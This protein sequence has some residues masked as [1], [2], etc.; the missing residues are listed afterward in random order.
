MSTAE[1]LVPARSSSKTALRL[2]LSLALGALGAGCSK[3]PTPEQHLAQ[4][5]QALERSKLRE[6][7]KEYSEV[8]RLAPGNTVA[9]R[10]LG[11]LYFAQGQLRQAFSFLKRAADSEPKDLDVQIMIARSYLAGRQFQPARDIAQQL[12][13]KQPGQ[14][15][16][17]ILLASAGVGLNDI[18][19]TRAFLE[20]VRPEDK[21]RAGYHVAQAILLLA[22]K[23]DGGAESELKAA[24]T[25]DPKWDAAHSGLATFYWAHNDLKHAEEEF[26]TA[27]AMAPKWSAQRLQLPEFLIETGAVDEAKRILEQTNRE[28][29]DYLPPR[30]LLMRIACAEK[31]DDDCAARAKAILEQ[32]PGNFDAL[33]Q[34]GTFKLAKGDV[35][36]AAREFEFV[37]RNYSPNPPAKY[38]LARAILLQ[39]QTATP[40]EGQK[41]IERAESNLLDAVRLDP[42]FAPAVLALA[43]LKIKKG[44][45]A[46]ALEYLRPLVE[47]N[48]TS[49]QAQ[50][51]LASAYVAE[52]N[53]TEALAVYRHMTELFPQDPKPSFL[54]GL[55][56][57]AQGQQADARKA[58]EKAIAI[59]PDLLPATEK[60][61]DLDL[62]N[63]QL[64]TALDRIQKQVDRDAHSAQALAIRAKV[65][66]AQNDLAHAEADLTRSIELNPKLE[67]SYL[68]L[69]RIYIV[70]NRQQQAIDRLS[71][72]SKNNNDIPALMQLA[73][74]QQSLKHY[75]EAR[76]AY[77]KLIGFAPTFAPAL[78][79][80]AVIYADHLGTLD[81]AYDL[82]KQ[83]RAAG[84][85]DPHIADTLGW[86]MFQRSDYRNALP[87]LQESAGKLADQPQIAFHL[88]MVH[89]MLGNEDASRTALQRAVQTSVPFPQRDEARQRL[90]MLTMDT[91]KPTDDAR[92]QLDSF[93]RQQPKDP[94][95]L[96]RLAQLRQR[97][98]GLDQAIVA[99][100][101]AIDA[102]PYFS[103][104]VRA[105]AIIYGQRPG[106]EAKAYDLAMKAREAY[107]HD[108]ELAKTLGI[109]NFQRGFYPQ[110]V[111]LLNQA[112]ATHTDDADVQLYLGRAYEELRK[113]EQCKASLQRAVALHLAP[114]L[115]D[116][117]RL[118]LANC[119]EMA[120]Q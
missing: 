2:A 100:Q 105:L 65:L 98:G 120:T 95:A 4:G 68:L 1:I 82:A 60:L 75:A 49:E 52:Q 115:A 92:A 42:T 5:N 7:E 34:D 3:Q 51:L 74:L 50:L 107:P 20:K 12:I 70:T 94:V 80:L 62:A 78:N 90:A 84:P 15:D 23:D 89:Y 59:S 64:A 47:K 21:K 101:K 18:D 14:D 93:L 8:L 35:A 41:A 37:N 44:S 46:A 86:I 111:E 56:L 11:T 104:A 79:N 117:A 28:T 32:D 109:L 16:A 45:P 36:S 97:D 27:A 116:D 71:A 17:L 106:Q 9:L 108:A 83:A 113:W 6:A 87:L 91:T 54:M 96:T 102:D 58:F 29:P 25:A 40:V 10:Q 38:Q 30:V 76:D 69:A 118:R 73:A 43:E 31:Q 39:S 63:H 57:L 19:G 67:L 26:R 119:T 13:E 72:F 110:S 103:P 53:A 33:F 61:V 88:G 66:V 85:A 55:V 114:K 112:A 24:V 48:P 77:E 81:R 22:Q 99:Y